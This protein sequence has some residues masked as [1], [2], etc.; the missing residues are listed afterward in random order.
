STDTLNP[1]LVAHRDSIA[2]AVNELDAL[3][4]RVETAPMPASYRA[5]AE[6]PQL[7]GNARAKILLDSL[8][9]VERDREGFG[10]AGS[11]DPVFVA[12]TSR[13]TDIGHAIQSLA[14]ARRDTLRGQIV[15]LNA[16]TVR[17]AVT[18]AP[19]ADTVAWIAERDSAESLVTQA[20]AALSDARQ[21][22][23]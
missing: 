21:H 18:P 14:Q 4:T 15:R 22:A 16:P 5:L 2:S 20:I 19:T 3:L 1:R 6:S 9:D 8:A 13:A 12:L 10:T 11:T 23:E 7:A 17:M